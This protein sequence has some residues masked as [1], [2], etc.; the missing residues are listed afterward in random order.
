MTMNQVNARN[1]IEESPAAR[2]L[3]GSVHGILVV[4]KPE[5]LTSFQMVKR[6]TKAFSLAKAGHCGTLDPFA[7][8]V[9]LVAV[10][11]GTRIVDQLTLHDKEYVCTVHFGIETDTLDKTGQPQ[12]IYDGPAL[13]VEV[14]ETAAKRFVGSYEQ[15]VPKFSAVHVGGHRLH[16]LARRGV[17]VP[18]PK[19]S[20]S[21]E[22]IELL[23]FEWPLATL[24]VRCSK[25]TYIRQLGADIGREMGCGAHLQT[26]RR[27]ASGPFGESRA[28]SF[29]EIEDLRFNGL[30]AE[31][32]VSLSEALAHL[33][34][35]CIEEEDLLKRLRNGDLD[36]SWESDQMASLPE[37]QSPVR[38]LTSRMQLAAL[39][40]PDAADG[41]GRRLRVFSF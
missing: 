7:T 19:R 5:G 37:G 34:M 24:R 11:L 15:E 30:W 12:E 10:N 1:W 29:N 2:D 36:R 3:S 17:D 18:L 8:G 21:I 31:R 35:A 23:G 9:L 40:W 6:V 13:G 39:W 14:C 4:D 25:G 41:S 27:T 38:I 32:V 28:L 16:E 22:S 33:P 20:V 26:L